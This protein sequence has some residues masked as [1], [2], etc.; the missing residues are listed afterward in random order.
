MRI[1]RFR[2]LISV[3]DYDVSINEYGEEEKTEKEV[4]KTWAEVKPL[5]STEIFAQGDFLST[6]HRI[7]TRYTNK[8]KP[9]QK[10]KLGE[11]EFEITGIR[12]FFE[13]HRFL[14]ILA[15]ELN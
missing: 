7:I 15:K 13:R 14:E 3:I 8:I 5:K 11:R 12:D 9:T 2:H 1:G 10:I 6:T 4:L